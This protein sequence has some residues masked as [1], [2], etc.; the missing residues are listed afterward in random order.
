[1]SNFKRL[2]SETFQ[3]GVKELRPVIEDIRSITATPVEREFERQVGK[4]SQEA[5]G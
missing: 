2:S 1:M 5:R 3:G 4:R